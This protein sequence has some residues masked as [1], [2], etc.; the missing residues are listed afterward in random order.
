MITC[1]VFNDNS[2]FDSSFPDWYYQPKHQRTVYKSIARET[3]E[4]FRETIDG[5]AKDSPAISP[6][7]GRFRVVLTDVS[8]EGN[9]DV[10]R[11]YTYDIEPPSGPK[12]TLVT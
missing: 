4:A 2:S 1:A 7:L 8:S 10:V 9:V 12:I 6:V 5:F 3:I 11:C